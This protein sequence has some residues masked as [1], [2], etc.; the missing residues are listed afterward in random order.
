VLTATA[1]P[2]SNVRAAQFVLRGVLISVALF[3]ILRI[4]VVETF[5]VLPLTLA[6]AA[7]AIRLFGAPALPIGVTLACS[8]ADVLSLCLG[9]VLA[10]PARWRDRTV[11]AAGAVALILVLNIVRIGTLGRAAAS[12]FWF[13]AL[14]LYIWP[15]V[16]AVAIGAYVLAWMRASNAE[17]RSVTVVAGATPVPLRRFIGFAGLFL[18]AFIVAAPLYLNN[19]AV[20]AVAA[21]VA[22]AAAAIL[23]GAGAQTYAAANVLWT[24]HGGFAVTEECISTPLIPLYLAGVAAFAPNWKRRSLGVVAAAP[25]F[26]ALGVVRLLVV[27]V[28]SSVATQSF[29]IHAFYQLLAGAAMI[30]GAAY[31]R[32]RDRKAFAWGLSGVG[33]AALFIAAAG[34]VYLRLV[35]SLVAFPVDDPQGA[36]AFV[37]VL[38]TALYF[39]LWTA[40]F[41]DSG[42]KRFVVG[43]AALVAS[44]LLGLAALDAVLDHTGMTMAV[45]DVRG[46]ALAAPGL[47][48][49]AMVS[50]GRAK[51]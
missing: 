27:A 19:A 10:Y 36:I 22:R 20:F 45:R 12:P 26:V 9:A 33:V 39:G 29:F 1:Q 8:G 31:W 49:A 21:F 43:L 35:A 14:H 17:A 11:G 44:Q 30:A 16:I 25:L 24:S 48:F 18:L 38:Q 15:L 41:V 40:A 28:P 50:L 5:V 3:G 7:V 42:W 47:V 51:R 34:P 32:H 37:P 4:G 6:Q 2:A 46:W 23:N 13:P